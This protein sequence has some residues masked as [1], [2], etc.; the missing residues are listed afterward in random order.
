MEMGYDQ[1][2]GKNATCSHWEP[3]LGRKVSD[4]QLKG[5]KSKFLCFSK[6]V[7]KQAIFWII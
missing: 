5:C 1:Q 2:R 4:V 3:I 6:S 7:S